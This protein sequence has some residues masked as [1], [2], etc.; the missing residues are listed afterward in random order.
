MKHFL[1]LVM[2]FVLIVGTFCIVAVAAE[3]GILTHNPTICTYEWAGINSWWR[4]SAEQSATCSL[5]HPI[6]YYTKLSFSDGNS[7]ADFGPKVDRA[8][9]KTANSADGYMLAECILCDLKK[10]ATKST[11][12]PKSN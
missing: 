10:N 7:D 11:S 4:A 3:K 12:I 8:Y 6:S 9:P 2:A 1:A 5:G